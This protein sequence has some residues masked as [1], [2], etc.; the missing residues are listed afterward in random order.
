M[1]LKLLFTRILFLIA[2]F[3][4]ICTKT[5]FGQ[6]DVKARLNHPFGTL[7]KM[8]VE[9]VDGDILNKKYYQ[10]SFL[11]KIKSIDST[12]LPE[13]IMMEFKDETGKFPNGVFQLYKYVKGKEA[14]VISSE[15]TTQLKKGYVGKQ[16]MIV[17]YETGEFTGIPKEY[18]K[19]QPVRQ[20]LSFHFKNYLIVVAVAEDN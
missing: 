7:L 14:G 12:G 19:Y 15:E 17:A 18:F 9:I 5:T 8:K 11:F 4:C 2:I 13:A 10:G 3:T 20:D 6:N 1:T 16:F